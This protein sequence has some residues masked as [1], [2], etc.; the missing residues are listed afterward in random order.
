[1]MARRTLRTVIL[2]YLLHWLSGAV[3]FSVLLLPAGF[4]LV[5]VTLLQPAVPGVQVL[6]L[7]PWTPLLV[8]SNGPLHFGLSLF[9]KAA[10]EP[11]V[12]RD[13]D[14]ASIIEHDT[15]DIV[16]SSTLLHRY[17]QMP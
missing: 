15:R 9:A 4:D 14:K 2:A 1:M 11:N 3:H 10:V 12:L 5:S 13:K 6:V 8:Q 7:P 17:C 16:A